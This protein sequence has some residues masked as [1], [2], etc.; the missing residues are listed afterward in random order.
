MFLIKAQITEVTKKETRTYQDLI[1][2]DIQSDNRG[3]YNCSVTS[4]NSVPAQKFIHVRSKYAILWPIIGILIQVIILAVITIR[5]RSQ[6]V[7]D[8]SDVDEIE[9]STLESEDQTNNI[10]RRGRKND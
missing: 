6:V 9:E 10:R 7:E 4:E 5:N 2:K 1:I 3:F 8:E